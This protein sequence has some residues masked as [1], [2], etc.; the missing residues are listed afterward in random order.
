MKIN[1]FSI[2][3]WFNIFDKH[4]DLLDDLQK[5][6]SNEYKK[7]NVFNYTDNLIAPVISAV[8]NERLTN[9]SISQINLQYNMDKVELHDLDKFKEKALKLYEL[10]T[11]NGMEISHTSVYVNGEIID[12]KA[13]AKI[14]KNTISSKL[15]SEDLVDITLKLG[16]KHEDLFYKI[17]TILNKKQMKLPKKV[18][19]HGRLI[20]IPLISWNGALVENEI[21]D[22]S[23]EINDKYSYDFT[24]NYHTTE[25][26]L[27]KM[28]YIL[29]ENLESDIESIIDQGTF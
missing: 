8:D 9:I 1:C 23:Y 20:P 19:E 29:A 22:I 13:L 26:Y 24:K 2:T 18:D 15:C 16:K 25:F 12:E 5:E 17:I 7:F 28:L 11:S 27:N 6:L 21:I 4:K 14:T 3:F 10:L